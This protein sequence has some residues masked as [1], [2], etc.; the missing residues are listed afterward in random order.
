MKAVIA[1]LGLL[2]MVAGRGFA[3]DGASP[4]R[5]L[6]GSSAYPDELSGGTVDPEIFR[7]LK[8][9]SIAGRLRF[10][11]PSTAVPAKAEV[12]LWSS[13]DAPGH[14]AARHWLP[15]PMKAPGRDRV[16]VL[17]VDNLDV[18]I[19][20]FVEA[21]D[22]G[23][24]LSPLRICAPRALGLEKP[25][26]PFWSF[27]EGFEEG[28]R[29]WRVLAPASGGVDQKIVPSPYNGKRALSVRIPE[30]KAS[31]TIATT[32]LREWHIRL[33]G[34]IGA[35]FQ[36][37]VPG[38]RGRVRLT[39]LMDAFSEEQRVSVLPQ[40]IEAGGDW[41]RIDVLFKDFPGLKPGRVDLLAF[42]FIGE[43]GREF[44]LD[45]LRLLGDWSER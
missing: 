9:D 37:R 2:A 3:A 39:I 31:V 24:K 38:G 12:R 33:Q 43:P 27:L 25:S 11:F 4:D 32:A 6:E 45:D 5:V 17:P 35:Q 30:G 13:V 15:V 41:T 21:A 34:A 14:W 36:T 29:G 44:L 1:F 40:T 18:P 7:E 20:Y 22:G 19:V 23:R 16:A 26:R 10:S 42:E 8:V 28:T